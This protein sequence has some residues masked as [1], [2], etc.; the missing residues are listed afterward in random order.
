MTSSGDSNNGPSAPGAELRTHF[1]VSGSSGQAQTAL[2][3]WKGEVGLPDWLRIEARDGRVLE[4]RLEP[5]GVLRVGRMKLGMPEPPQVADDL[6]IS[7]QAAILRHDGVRWWLRRRRECHERV[8]TV[9]GARVLAADEE[10][11]LVHGTFLQIGQARAT[12]VDRRY[13]TPAVPAGAVDLAT[14]LLG[15]VGF[16]QEVGGLISLGRRGQIALVAFAPT[17]SSLGSLPTPSV[18]AIQAIHEAWPRLAVMHDEGV[19]AVLIPDGQGSL[20]EIETAIRSILAVR[21]LTAAVGHWAL[22]AKASDPSAEVDGA[23]SAVRAVLESGRVDGAIDL[24][25]L[26]SSAPIS[27]GRGLLDAVAQ[28]RRRSTLLLGIEESGALQRVGV[29]VIPAL[30]QELVSIVAARAG[31]K[32]HV[33]RLAPGVVGALLPQSLDVDAFAADIHREWQA[34]PAIV[35]GKIELPRSLCWETYVGDPSERAAEL[36]R[37]C[38]EPSGVLTALSASMPYPIASRVALAS[39]SMSAVERVKLLFDVLEGA[40]RMVASVLAAAYLGAPVP[41]DGSSPPGFDELQAFARG[42]STRAAYPLGK[43]RELA[44]IVAHGFTGD[45][46][47]GQMAHELLRAR[48]TGNETLEALANQIHPLR[49][50]FAHNVY[51]EAQAQRD[52]PVFEQVA[53]AVLRSLRPLAA[54]SLVT[55]E[56]TEH[57]LYGEVQS[58]E[59]VDHTGPSEAG[60]RRR[61]GLKSDVRLAPVVYLVRWR[62][63]LFLPLEP[64]LRR[65][66]RGNAFDLF[67]IHHLPRA[68]A[69]SY[70]AVL[71]GEEATF[72]IEERRM[73]P[74]ARLLASAFASR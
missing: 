55:I 26:P 58:V 49:N 35:D 20:V 5:R 43:W 21:G 71:T 36:S 44:R 45:D 3:I 65:R 24:R 63:G 10:A 7:S 42:T 15:K 41:I 67:W 52:L 69:C 50:R 25:A 19:A 16:S 39:A 12:L 46:P 1:L 61:V 28:D 59:Y 72:D 30:E 18:L 48:T 4:L 62:E 33:A 68:G 13:V 70:G 56:R 8:P 37:E 64:F 17:S 54:W 22:G 29:Q 66:A 2:S 38:A 23:L 9:V 11:P 47:I 57:D 34:R 6:F 14:G 31:S 73:P 40:W 32:A 51:S 53:R 74:R 60:V 27:A